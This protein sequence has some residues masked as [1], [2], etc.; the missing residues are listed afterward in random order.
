MNNLQT[1]DIEPSEL[2]DLET[3]IKERL[4]EGQTFK[5]KQ[6][7]YRVLDLIKDDKTIKGKQKILIERELDRYISYNRFKGNNIMITKIFDIPLPVMDKQIQGIYIVY[8]EKALLNYFL[9]QNTEEIK[10]SSSTLFTVLGMN[11]KYYSDSNTRNKLVD[12]DKRFDTWETD[13]FFFRSYSI[14]KTIL[15]RAFKNMQDRSEIKVNEEYMIGIQKNNST[16]VDWHTADPI[17]QSL[18][19]TIENEVRTEMGYSSKSQIYWHNKGKSFHDKVYEKIREKYGWNAYYNYYHII[20]SQKHCLIRALEEKELELNKLTLNEKVI[21]AV[22]KDAQNRYDRQENRIKESWNKNKDNF[23]QSADTY[24][25]YNE[26]MKTN[27]RHYTE[28][29]IDIQKMLSDFFLSIE[30]E[31]KVIGYIKEIDKK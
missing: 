15:T 27:V 9:Q 24:E 23:K 31:D 13:N 11:N 30:E 2:S 19:L 1:D 17:E 10:M 29:Y 20:T 18:I 25:E 6:E 5:N 12:K 7:L 21:E 28:E 4:H 22:N 16:E 26:L 8:I 3:K 14:M